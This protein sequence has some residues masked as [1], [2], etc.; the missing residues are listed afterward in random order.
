MRKQNNKRDFLI[1]LMNNKSDFKIAKE[2]NWY[3]IPC[4]T[5]M[6]PKSV[7]DKTLKY[8]AFYHTKI[9]SKDAYCVQWYSE[10]K[11]ISIV[12]RKTLLPYIQND[13]KA[14]D[15]YYKIE[16]NPLQKLSIPIVSNRP[17]RLLFI[18]T[19]LWHFQNSRN[20]NDLFSESPLEEEF[21]DALKI[22]KIEAERQYLINT[23]TQMFYLDFAIFC[24]ER[25]INIECD[26][27]AFHLSEINVKRDKKRNNILSSLGWSIL[28]FTTADIR[29][30]LNTTIKY[31]K[32]TINRY[33]GIEIIS[34]N[35]YKFFERDQNQ[36]S[37]F[38]Y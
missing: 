17:R 38:D 5:K 14:D 24:K 32:E 36:I 1:A 15:E 3:R 6:V 37:L 19:T 13:F 27:D 22:A 23:E 29:R 10:V 11:N 35:T 28:R 20:I 12:S 25:N 4:A 31:V 16:F 33:G 8:I 9:F 2:Q 30:N 34:D 26:G 18:P 21:W 7:A